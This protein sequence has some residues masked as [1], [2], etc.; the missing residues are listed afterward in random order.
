[1]KDLELLGRPRKQ[2][3]HGTA[4]V[5]G[6]SIAGTVTARILADHFERVVLVDPELEDTEKPKTR[7]L[8]Y[9][10]THVFLSLFLEGARKLWPDFDSEYLAATGRLVPAESGICYSGVKSLTPYQDYPSGS[11]PET[12]IV[13]RSTAQKVLSRLLIQHSTFANITII[14]GTVRGFEATSDAT[15]IQSVTVRKLDG[16]EMVLN[17]VAL[18]AECTGATQAGLKWLR[19]AGFSLPENIRCSYNANLRYTTLNF[20]VPAEL[21]AKLPIPESARNTMLAYGNIEHFAYGS[22]WFGLD[23]TDNN[24]SMLLIL[25]HTDDSLPRVASDVVPWI[26]SLRTHA[27]VPTWVLETI[28]IICEQGEP[29][30]DH[31]RVAPQSY[32]QYHK[33]PAGTLPSNFVA[34]GDATMQLNPIH[35]QGFSKILL[36]GITLN[37]LLVNAD[38]KASNVP[39]DFAVRYFKSTKLHGTRSPETIFLSEPALD[40]GNAN[41][42]PMDGE[43]KDTG[44]FIRLF[45]F[46]LM[47]AAMQD[48]EVA[49]A[50]W[51]V[52]QILSADRLLLA[53]TVLWKIMWSQPRFWETV[54]I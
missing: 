34:I 16:T 13:R 40:Y 43:T 22:R 19:K 52:R 2:K 33:A 48:A 5:C 4:V 37:A 6:G 45:E 7:I 26:L 32:V 1:M 29:W 9:N 54:H 42:E 47:S 35:G 12:L 24:T 25:G 20:T 27:K 18:V 50:L 31:I 46:K 28:E 14:P 11:F 15:S 36:N 30:F 53:P 21:E 3:L 51:H 17:D 44:R 8:Q 23:L 10:A 41:C 39:T 38:P 49:S